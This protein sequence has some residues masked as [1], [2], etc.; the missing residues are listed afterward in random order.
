MIADRAMGDPMMATGVRYA[1]A[2]SLRSDAVRLAARAVLGASRRVHSGPLPINDRGEALDAHVAA[3]IRLAAGRPPLSSLP[4]GRARAE[5]DGFMRM[6]DV[7]RVAIPRVTDRRIDGPHGAI[8]IRVYVPNE[9]AQR[10]PM[11]VW[12]HGGGFVIGSLDGYDRVLR[13]LCRHAGVVVVSVDYRLSPEARFPVAFEDSLAAARWAFASA[14][15]LGADPSRIALGG[16]SAGGNLAASVAIALRD[17]HRRDPRAPMPRMQ[18]LVY[19][20]T[21][22][23]RQFA[24]HRTLGEGYL[25]TRDMIAWFMERYLR[26]KDDERDP[27]AS[28]LLAAD[29]R[30]LPPAWITVA[31][32]DPL[33]DEGEAYAEALR[34]SGGRVEMRYEPSLI[35]GF[36]TMGGLIPRAAECVDAAARALA[37]GLAT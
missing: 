2:V 16:D 35:H 31:G 8:P 11:L 37:A 36:F 18:L 21:D 33:R 5:M 7:P 28:P 27:R 30:D 14:P 34:A 29:H 17:E 25:L 12:F 23:R 24:S 19:P 13:H 20:A 9:R 4:T 26:S 32:F 1:R 15:S 22:L 6:T 3:L 10:Q